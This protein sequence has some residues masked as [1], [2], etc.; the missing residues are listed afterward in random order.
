MQRLLLFN[1]DDEQF[2]VRQI[3]SILES[4]KRFHSL[5]FNEPGGALIEAQYSEGQD[6][7]IVRLSGNRET[8]SLSGTS[9][10]ALQA[11]LIFQRR[12]QRPLRLIDT[13]YTFDLILQEF[14]NIEELRAAIESAQA[15]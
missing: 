12:L 9:D 8:I 13:D 14:A 11:V 7:T 6:S 2:A 4:E 15:S 10:A 3:Q 5:R 1:S